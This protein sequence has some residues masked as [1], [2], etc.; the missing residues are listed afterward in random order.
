MSIS[1]VTDANFAAEVEQSSTP[2]LVDFWAEWCGPCR[3]MNPILEEFS[4]AHEGRIKVAKLNVDDSQESASRFKVL[5]IP[6]MLLFQDGEVV[7]QLVGAMSR[8]RLEEALA[9]WVGTPA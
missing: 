8:Q 3:M 7:K 4:A 2:V 1:Q 9:E 6:T 5:S